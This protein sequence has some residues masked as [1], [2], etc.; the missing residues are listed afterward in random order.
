MSV[1]WT[2]QQ[3]EAIRHRSGELV[4]SASAGSGKTAVIIERAMYLIRSGL[5]DVDQL[6]IVTFTE[7]AADQLK[8]RLRAALEE[9]YRSAGKPDARRRLFSQLRLVD[10][11]WISTIHA[12]SR[13]LLRNHHHLLGLAAEMTVLSAEESALLR[14]RVAEEL[15]EECY[16]AEDEFGLAFRRLVELYG[17]RSVDG[18]LTQAVLSTHAFLTS[19]VDPD[20][21]LA[22]CRRTYTAV[23]SRD[24]DLSSHAI[25]QYLGCQWQS[26]L[27]RLESEFGALI[28]TAGELSLT[29]MADHLADLRALVGDAASRLA[30]NEH[31]AALENLAGRV[32]RSPSTRNPDGDPKIDE[33]KKRV[34]QAKDSLKKTVTEIQNG[35]SAEALARMTDQAPLIETFLNL[36]E[37][38]SSRLVETKSEL[39]Q[40][41]FDDL[42][43]LALKV[44]RMPQTD[45]PAGP[46]VAE[47][48]RRDFRFVMVDEYQDVNEL[49]DAIVRSV[50]RQDAAG[51][52]ENLMVVGDVKQSI[53]RFRLAEPEVFQR[54]CRLAATEADRVRRI[55]LREN[56]R[57]QMGVIDTVNGVFEQL[58]LGGPLQL[59][60]D[61]RARLICGA[62]S[63]G[64]SLDHAGRT[65]LL[66]LERELGGE[67]D[68]EDEI[69]GEIADLEVIEREAY[70]VAQRI[71]TLLDDPPIIAADEGDRALQQEDI[72]ILLR[73]MKFTANRFVDMLRRFGLGAYCGQVEAFLEYPE[74]AAV[75]ALLEV[76][77]NP[78]QDIPLATV[79]WRRSCA[80]GW[81]DSPRTTWR[82]FA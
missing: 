53:Y 24:F 40:L 12:F 82:G 72:V 45:G 19:L 62:G 69:T 76:I 54:L 13:Q 32:G 73:T 64:R 46:A 26:E 66:L 5:A 65:E 67:A 52:A 41:D 36:V 39:G 50:C 34:A 14:A 33:F 37:N 7:D 3:L 1:N 79:L 28:E 20:G 17:G 22:D 27:R 18:G 63:Q 21:W 74:I 31:S 60:Y 61:D 15:F 35:F 6:L 56:F 58:L 81:A 57:S 10:R 43:R 75:V 2:E 25:W 77:D 38:F 44:L 68:S 80:V 4:V 47:K 51:R 71:K 70:L 55:D 48:Y 9:A 8:E 49:Q 42:Q 78:Y 23:A 30:G 59:E 29:S 16:A 11:A